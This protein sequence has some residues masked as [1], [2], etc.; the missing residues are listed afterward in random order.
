[1]A[2]H[3]RIEVVS[4]PVCP[5]CFIGK[6][7]LEQALAL[8]PEL[9]ADVSWR[10]FQ[11]NP[12]MPREG[13]LR[14]AHYAE[15]FG[16][17]RAR[18]IRATMRDT[19]REEGIEFGDAPDAVSPNTLQ[20]HVLMYWAEQTDGVDT[21]LLADKLFAAHHVDCENLGDPAVLAR[22]AGEVGMPAAQVEQRLRAGSDEAAVLALIEEARRRGVTGV[23]FFV[24]NERFGVS[25]AQPAEVLAGVFDQVL[26]AA[27]ESG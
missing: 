4:D 9:Q 14:S 15:L 3:L 11:L 23:P 12:D 25:G 22:I 20:A 5:W 21:S 6:R 19:G 17:E 1:M 13:R 27:A 10:P 16:E 24:L 26:A 2:Q 7:R 18:K 8:R